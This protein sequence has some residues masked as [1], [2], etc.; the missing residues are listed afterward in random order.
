MRG[1]SA[2]HSRRNI[3]IAQ[4]GG[5]TAILNCS[6][7]G[8][9]KEV[10]RLDPAAVV[11]GVFEGMTGL[12]EGHLKPL[13]L[14]RSYEWLKLTP[15]AALGAGR[16]QVTEADLDACIRH[17]RSNRIHALV[18]AGGNGTMLA[19]QKL[20][21][22][23]KELNYE[24]QIIGIPKT[25]DNDLME[26]DHS[27]G[28]ASAAKYVAHAVR[29][30]SVDLA[31]MKSFEQVRVIETM[32]RN[33]GW[34][35]AAS[36]YFN[37]SEADAP[38]LVYLPEWPFDLNHMLAQVEQQ[39]L[40]N[41]YCVVVVGEGLKDRNGQPVLQQKQAAPIGPQ[42]ARTP[43]LLGGEGAELARAI[44][45]QLGRTARYENLG[46]LQ[47]C[48]SFLVSG[49][50][51]LEAEEAGKAAARLVFDGLSELMVTIDRLSDEPYRFGI[52]HV[53]LAKVAGVERLLDA[54]FISGSGGIH[55]SFRRWLHPLVSDDPGM[56]FVR[57]TL[58]QS[59]LLQ[60]F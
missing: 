46:I 7:H 43:R 28:F 6:L 9:M 29:D 30:L 44:R 20:A 16:K 37:G 2:G 1:G 55:D 58:R 13:D 42:P 40:R 31:S 57:R 24:L 21:E 35:A 34:L 54:R 45:D 18:M 39:C 17:L 60:A 19:C 23:A 49:Q 36:T 4:M 11:T 41:G 26:T 10:Q 15:G 3:A 14:D 50:D 38:H 5:P 48:A 22:K 59:N 25:V 12:V 8:F 52:G 47:R 51:K 56:S 27:P 33:A 53:P 32:G